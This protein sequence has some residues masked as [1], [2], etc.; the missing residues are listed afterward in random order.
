MLVCTF[1]WILW[2]EKWLW[3][4]FKPRYATFLFLYI[5]NTLNTSVS[6][7]FEGEA[8]A[9]TAGGDF[10]PHVVTVQPGEVM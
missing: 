9:N 8:F 5:T 4:L 6:V 7:T 1:V 2:L 10:T 3:K